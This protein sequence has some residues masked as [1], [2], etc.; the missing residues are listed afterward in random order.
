VACQDPP[1]EDCAAPLPEETDGP[2]E[3][4]LDVELLF[5][6]EFLDVELLESSSDE[7]LDVPELSDVPEDVDD[8]ELLFELVE[9]LEPLLVAAVSV[10]ATAAKASEPTA[11]AVSRPPVTTPTRRKPLSRLF[12]KVLLGVKRRRPCDPTL[13]TV[14]TRPV[15]LL[16]LK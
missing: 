5:E 7:V 10:L 1:E 15:R 11:V 4:P 6:V 16:C 12:M 13:L 14:G 9:D 3:K 2:D 8:P